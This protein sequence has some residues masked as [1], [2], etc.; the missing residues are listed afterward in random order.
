[1]NVETEKLRTLAKFV[2]ENASKFEW[3]LQGLGMLRLYIGDDTR[4]HIWDRR[5][6]APGATP[7]HD[8]QQWGLHSTVLSGSM[9]NYRFVE[10]GAGDAYLYKTIRAGV[11]C[12]DLSGAERINLTRQPAEIYGPG[13]CYSQ[14]PEEIHESVPDNGTVTLMKKT[15][16]TTP[17]AARVFWPAGELWGSAEP[18]N[19]TPREVQEMA[20]YALKRWNR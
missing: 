17:E 19:A 10:G 7:I 2:L 8:H 16:T 13:E 4:L 5:F 20:S 6:A 9:C 11:G 14:W 3:S 1:M 12:V 18:R 15:P